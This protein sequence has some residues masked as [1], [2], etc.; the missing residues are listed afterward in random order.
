MTKRG[1]TR[2][3]DLYARSER[4]PGSDCWIWQGATS[5]DGAS[6]RIWTFDHDRGDKRVMTGPRAAWNIANGAGPGG[7]LAYMHCC[8]SLCVNPA[9]VRLAAN[10]AEI[11]A[12]IRVSGS[13]KGQCS[14]QRRAGLEKAWSA[15]GIVVTSPEVV[16]AVRAA[17]GTNI[18][19][20]AR[21]GIGHRV[22]ST[23][24]LR[25]SHRDVAEAA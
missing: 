5:D 17:V 10:R 16:R 14:T 22:V 2:I 25:K 13:R 15:R 7:R 23:I 3:V 12:R 20:A 24:R 4:R 1:T 11:G 6:P 9:H 21:Y 18:A 19:I 8:N